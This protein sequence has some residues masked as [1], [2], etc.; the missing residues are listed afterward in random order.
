MYILVGNLINTS[1]F[2]VEDCNKF[3]TDERE[4]FLQFEEDHERDRLWYFVE[5]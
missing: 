3:L 5:N 4:V 1:S 2:T